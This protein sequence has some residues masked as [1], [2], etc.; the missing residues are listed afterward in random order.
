MRCYICI[1]LVFWHI[2]FS[3]I[4]DARFRMIPIHKGGRPKGSVNKSTKNA[5]EAIGRFVDGNADRVQLWLDEVYERDGPRAAFQCFV[6]LI[7]SHVPKLNR[8]EL[9][10]E[11][12]PVEIVVKWQT[13]E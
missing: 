9:A 1:A 5:R 6:D 3:Q 8:S 12:G 11:K 13:S 10:G 4:K 2:V 7:E